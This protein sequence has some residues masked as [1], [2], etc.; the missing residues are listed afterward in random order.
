MDEVPTPDRSDFSLCKEARHGNRPQLFSQG[1]G[2]VVRPSEEALAATTTAEHQ[3]PEWR[4]VP[5]GPVRGKKGGQIFAGRAC[6]PKVKLDRL[7]FLHD[8]ADRNRPRASIRPEQIPN[9]KI[10]PLKPIPMFVNHDAEMQGA[11][12]IF[13]RQGLEYGLQLFQCRFAAQLVNEIALSLGHHK[14]LTDQTAALRDDG[15]NLHGP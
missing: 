7:T 8:I 6:V 13:F 9:E 12:T 11:L 3:R 2:I 15:S 1:S 4:A 14:P 10:S 5:D